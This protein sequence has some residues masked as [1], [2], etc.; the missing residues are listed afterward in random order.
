MA[1]GVVGIA[2]RTGF[3]TGVPSETF[4]VDLAVYGVGTDFSGLISFVEHGGAGDYDLVFTPTAAGDYRARWT[5]DLSGA[6]FTE[7]WR[8]AT[9]AQADPASAVTD[10]PLI[11]GS[12]WTLASQLLSLTRCGVHLYYVEASGTATDGETGLP[13]RITAGT[14]LPVSQAVR[15]GLVT[16]EEGWSP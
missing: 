4:T 10:A 6:E 3:S 12:T 14:C 16:V 7:T 2:V 13:V 15:Y 1:D 8:V 11:A 5:G 9:A